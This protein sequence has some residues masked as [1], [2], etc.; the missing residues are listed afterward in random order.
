ME[1]KKPLS[2]SPAPWAVP[3]VEQWKCRGF[4]RQAQGPCSASSS[5]FRVPLAAAAALPVARPTAWKLFLYSLLRPRLLTLF[6]GLVSPR[7]APAPGAFPSPGWL[8][9]LLSSHHSCHTLCGSGLRSIAST[10]WFLLSRKCLG[11]DD[12]RTPVCSWGAGSR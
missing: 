10:S 1:G 7:A 2:A 9:C 3:F 5:A 11:S 12:S 6:S 4:C 8:R